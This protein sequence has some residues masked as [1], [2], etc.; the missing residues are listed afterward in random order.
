[1]DADSEIDPQ[2]IANAIK[3]FNL[4]NSIIAV[5]SYIDVIKKPS[6]FYWLQ[7]IEYLIAFGLKKGVTRANMDYLLPGPGS[8]FLRES[9]LEIGGY[10]HDTI[11]EDLG[12]SLK[13]VDSELENKKL[14]FASDV[15]TRTEPVSSWQDLYR[16]RK[17]WIRGWFQNLLRYRNLLLS[18]DKKHSW[19]LTV[20]YLPYLV[21]SQ[22][23]GVFQISILV[24]TM[25]IGLIAGNPW[26]LV[27]QIVSIQALV[28]YF[29]FSDVNLGP[30]S[31]RWKLSLGS[32]SV[33]GML[34]GLN[35]LQAGITVGEYGRMLWGIVRP[36]IKDSG[37][38]QHVSRG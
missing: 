7:K 23:F 27:I 30:K 16:Q 20:F 14:Y 35:L 6:L 26:I 21:I 19:Q 17:R 15:I 11:T 8:F 4:D 33:I 1:L 29:I 9:I 32:F 12:L 24:V 10:D 3:H 28:L 22:F 18:T 25:V 2:A 38:W 31:E 36:D 5:S 13:I 34:V 37:R